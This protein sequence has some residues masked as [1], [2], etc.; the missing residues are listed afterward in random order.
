LLR[1]RIVSSFSARAAALAALVPLASGC[2]VSRG[3][4]GAVMAVGGLAVTTTGT[5]LATDHCSPDP[6]F[7]KD[8]VGAKP[9]VGIPVAVFGG[10]AMIAGAALV[11][12][13]PDHRDS[14]HPSHPPHPS[15]K[16]SPRPE[17]PPR[18]DP[19]N[20]WHLF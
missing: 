9:D 5:V 12:S 17:K 8:V 18:P 14:S 4:V 19:T 20:D 3:Q 11:A 13:A 2:G 6:G 16:S 10:L 15:P 7:C 1:V